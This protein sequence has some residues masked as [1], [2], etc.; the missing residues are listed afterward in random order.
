MPTSGAASGTPSSRRSSIPSLGRGA[1]SVVYRASPADV[2]WSYAGVRPLYDDDARNAAAVS[3]DYVFDL[4][5]AGAPALSIFGGKLTTHRRLAEHALTRLTPYLPGAGPPWTA[6]SVLP[7]GADL[8]AGGVVG[9]TAELARDHP[10]LD[11]A[12]ASRLA[13]SYGSDARQILGDAR[14][15]ADLGRCFGHG[16]YAA[17]LRWLVEREWAQTAEDVLW[18]R[19]KLGLHLSAAERATVAAWCA[20][21]WD[22]TVVGTTESAWN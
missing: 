10:F 11:A 14:T 22:G 13:A 15:A 12:T 4:D 7:G 9:L 5:T 1:Y 20:S 2:V 8:P 16:L 6:G 21:H 17:E 3:R 18:R 19:S